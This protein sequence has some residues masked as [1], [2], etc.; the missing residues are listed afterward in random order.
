[1]T[2]INKIAEIKIRMARGSSLINE[3]RNAFI[4]ATTLKLM[5]EMDTLQAVLASLIALLAFY[6]VGYLDI[7]KIKLFQTEQ[8][9]G[10]GKY[11]PHLARNLRK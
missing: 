3:I 7:N 9:L 5:F 8:E 4:I 10:T 2:F 1:M 11:N 6:V